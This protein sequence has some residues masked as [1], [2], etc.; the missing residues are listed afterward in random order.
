MFEQGGTPASEK[1]PTTREQKLL[2]WIDN[3]RALAAQ[4]EP[5]PGPETAAW[6][7]DSVDPDVIVD[8]PV[9][10]VLKIAAGAQQVANWA[11][12][13]QLK[14]ISEV[15]AQLTS[16][17]VPRPAVMHEDPAVRAQVERTRRDVSE[18]LG[19]QETVA[20]VALACK[21]SEHAAGSRLSA[22]MALDRRLP[23]TRA[24]LERGELDWPKLMAIVD[25]VVGLTDA[26]AA[27]VEEMVLPVAQEMNVPAL[28]R[29]LAEAV[30]IADSRSEEVGAQLRRDERRVCFTPIGDGATELWALL[31]APVAEAAKQVIYQLADAAKTDG[32]ERTADQRRADVLGDLLTN[33]GPFEGELTPRPQPQVVVT[34]PMET[35]LGRSEAPGNLEG[36]G[37]VAASIAREVAERGTWRCAVVDGVHGTLLGLGRATYT[38]DYRPGKPLVDFVRARDAT[39]TFPGCFRSA[40]RCDLD[41]RVRHPAGPTCECNLGALCR[42]HHRLKHEAGFVMATSSDPEQPPGTL[43]WRTPAGL[44]YARPPTR[45]PVSRILRQ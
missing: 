29:A 21:I 14:A 43:A 27:T 41:H 42:K 6:L 25:A 24:A 33:P 16:S 2:D 10:E 20:E 7:E 22:A 17:R 44:R 26:A 3:F 5:A 36:Y 40:Q 39:C 8:F 30:I 37:P 12:S 28:R 45:L 32:D 13:V 23:K 1:V 18:R 9:S 38:P 11:L 31:S 19:E 15:Y 4:Y 34:V 35:L